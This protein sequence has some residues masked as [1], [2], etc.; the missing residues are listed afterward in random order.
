MRSD[1]QKKNSKTQRGSSINLIESLNQKS[2]SEVEKTLGEPSF[3]IYNSDIGDDKNAY[4]FMSWY[5]VSYEL[6]QNNI[7]GNHVVESSKSL[8]IRF[9]SSLHVVGAQVVSH[10]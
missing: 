6:N 7:T 10:S 4:Y 3:I 1:D 5:Y 2:I 8:I 9:D